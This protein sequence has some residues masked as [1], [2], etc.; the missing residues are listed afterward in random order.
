MEVDAP[1]PLIASRQNSQLLLPK[2]AAHLMSSILPFYNISIAPKVR[3]TLADFQISHSRLVIP[4]TDNI[5]RMKSLLEA[6][7]ALVETKNAVE[8]TDYN[9]QA[10]KRQLGIEEGE[11]ERESM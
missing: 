7:T 6:A 9:V 8:K 1:E 11:G 3:Q 2:V 10:T 5:E 4:T